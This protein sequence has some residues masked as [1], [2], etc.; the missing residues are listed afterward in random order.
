MTPDTKIPLQAV[1]GVICDALADL[2]PN[3]QTRA[4]ESV[5]IALGVED[6]GFQKLLQLGSVVAARIGGHEAEN[7]GPCPSCTI[8]AELS[9]S[10]RRDQLS[11]LMQTLDMSQKILLMEILNQ[12][13]P[14]AAPEAV[15]R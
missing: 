15:S 12:V 2:Q 9:Q 10:L 5:R 7:N 11:V 8:V 1:V 14:P 4:L 3:D 6:A 13:R